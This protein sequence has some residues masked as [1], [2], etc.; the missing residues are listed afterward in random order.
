MVSMLSGHTSQGNAQAPGLALELAPATH[1]DA[2]GHVGGAKS[3]DQGFAGLML[4]FLARL[5]R[6]PERWGEAAGLDVTRLLFGDSEADLTHWDGDPCTG[7][8]LMRFG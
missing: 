4:E 6:Y 8:M 2:I 7:L 5:G 1:P 3:L